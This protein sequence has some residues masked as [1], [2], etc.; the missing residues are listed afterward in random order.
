MQHKNKTRPANKSSR[1]NNNPNRNKRQFSEPIS[2]QSIHTTPDA[3][4]IVQSRVIPPPM[5]LIALQHA[6]NQISQ[7][8]P[9]VAAAGEA[10]LVDEQDVLLEACVE[11]GL[12]AELADDGIVVA[13]NV[14]VDAVH[15]LEDLADESGKRLGERHTC[16]K[17]GLD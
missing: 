13:V 10:V 3:K 4:L 16:R 7:G 9:V 8:T 12:E 17:H 2:F 15:A 5:T 14:C 11:M 1:P 6:I